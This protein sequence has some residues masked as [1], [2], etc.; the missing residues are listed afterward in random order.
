GLLLGDPISQARLEDIQLNPAGTANIVRAG[1]RELSSSDAD[2]PA[3]RRRLQASLQGVLIDAPDSPRAI[4]IDF[5][6][7]TV[8]EQALDE[9]IAAAIA[10]LSAEETPGGRE[11]DV[12]IG[13][14]P[15]A[16]RAARLHVA[17]THTD[18][19]PAFVP[20]LSNDERDKLRSD[21]RA[22]CD[23][24]ASLPPPAQR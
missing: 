16:D 11:Y 15:A 20:S 13:L 19:T 17:L 18:A 22:L 6:K 1:L 24:A 9:T 2:F 4:W 12:P 5:A 23:A 8:D 21:V 10:T 14:L 7:A 3:Q